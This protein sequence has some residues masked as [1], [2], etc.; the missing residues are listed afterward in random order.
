[1]DCLRYEAL[2]RG[3]ADRIQGILIAGSSVGELMRENPTAN[4]CL[5]IMEMAYLI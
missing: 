3:V 2:A 5:C 1:M 4:N